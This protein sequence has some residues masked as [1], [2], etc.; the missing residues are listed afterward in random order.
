MATAGYDGTATAGDG[1]AATAGHGGIIC[2]RYWD[3]TRYRLAVGYVG[4]DGI[5][6]DTP[7][8]VVDGRLVV[9]S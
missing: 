9:A 4:E 1:G 3:T 2:I 8:R 5:L 7:Y 6:P